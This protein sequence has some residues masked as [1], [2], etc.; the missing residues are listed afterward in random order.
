MHAFQKK[1]NICIIKYL[2]T[3]VNDLVHLFYPKP[4]QNI[5][6]IKPPSMYS[7]Y[8]DITC[9]RWLGEFDKGGWISLKKGLNVSSKWLKKQY[10]TK[11]SLKHVKHKQS[12]SKDADNEVTL[13]HM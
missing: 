10:F 7:T 13:F 11:N 8:N 3:I 5:L 1:L 9:F 12:K 6:T 2:F 4:I